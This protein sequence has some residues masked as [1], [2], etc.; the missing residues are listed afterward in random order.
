MVVVL[1]ISLLL[2]CQTFRGYTET[3]STFLRIS[4]YAT[5]NSTINYTTTIPGLRNSTLKMAR[6]TN[7]LSTAFQPIYH[8]Y[9]HSL[10]DNDNLSTQLNE[11]QK[12]GIVLLRFIFF[13]IY[14]GRYSSL[15][16]Q[17][18]IFYQLD[19]QSFTTYVAHKFW[20][21]Q[22][23]FTM[24][25]RSSP[26]LQ[27]GTTSSAAKVSASSKAKSSKPK[28]PTK[29]QMQKQRKAVKERKALIARNQDELKALKKKHAEE[30]KAIEA[31]IKDAQNMA[32]A[33]NISSDDD[34]SSQ[35]SENSASSQSDSSITESAFA[36]SAKSRNTKRTAARRQ[37]KLD[38]HLQDLEEDKES[39]DKDGDGSNSDSSQGTIINPARTAAKKSASTTSKSNE[40]APDVIEV[41]EDDVTVVAKK[42]LKPM[43]AKR[44][45][46]EFLI[47]K[48]RHILY[49]K[50]KITVP[51]TEEEP[52]KK[53]RSVFM[54]YMTTLIKID[55]RLLI[56]EHGDTSN[57][58]YISSPQQIPDT[59]TTIQEFFD[60][61]YRPKREKQIIWF[62]LKIG[63]DTK[64]ESNFFLDAKCLFDDKKKHALFRKDIQAPETEVIGYFLYSHGKQNRERLM[65]LLS[66]L[67]KECYK[68]RHPVSVR[69]QKIISKYSATGKQ[70][71]DSG[72]EEESKAYHVEVALL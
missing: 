40:K 42:N 21:H 27:A 19:L 49:C 72:Q 46:D 41:Q 54:S 28:K 22:K 52:C 63:I 44:P 53:L 7:E 25:K 10:D 16:R 33:I 6:F 68:I 43:K 17:I 67:L 60:G 35:A 30:Q 65:E 13:T 69:W 12:I 51:S 38:Q 71:R 32:S 8:V 18:L 37:Q 14:S 31:M 26:R 39:E 56:F 59:P 70:K 47:P 29:T 66:Y 64:E 5:R 61:N 57:K 9:H 62:Q 20:F 45:T 58:R 4:H 15:A 55:K 3:F 23:L 48:R 50:G 2:S 1:L 34:N 24:A 11:V 36:K